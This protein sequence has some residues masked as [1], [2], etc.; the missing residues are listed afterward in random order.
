M[1]NWFN[2]RKRLITINL[3]PSDIHTLIAGLT[4]LRDDE[5]KWRAE[6]DELIALLRASLEA[7]RASKVL[8]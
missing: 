4:I 2:F 5:P 8:A 3:W 7:R 6:V 1:P